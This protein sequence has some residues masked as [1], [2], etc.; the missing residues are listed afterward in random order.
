MASDTRLSAHGAQ[1]FADRYAKFLTDA[2]KEKGRRNERSVSQRF[3][4]D[5][6][7]QVCGVGDTLQAGIEFEF[8]VRKP[9]TDTVG[10]IDA[11]WPGVLLIEKSHFVQAK[12]R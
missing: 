7:T 2:T 4:G 10:W 3:W 9:S 12:R 8:P 6:F 11:L 5:F 1:L